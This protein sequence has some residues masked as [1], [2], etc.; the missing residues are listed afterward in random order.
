MNEIL[1]HVIHMLQKNILA[2]LFSYLIL[3]KKPYEY[4]V[5]D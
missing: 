4:T 5:D 3:E 1:E 2:M